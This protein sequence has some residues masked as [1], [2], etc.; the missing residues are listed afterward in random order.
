MS[1]NDKS[2]P[3]PKPQAPAASEPPKA[4]QVPPEKMNKSFSKNGA[5]TRGGAKG[6]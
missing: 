4:I 6:K 5:Q 3:A 1:N 2:A